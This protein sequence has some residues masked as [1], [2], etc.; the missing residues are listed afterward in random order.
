M[1]VL[2][3]PTSSLPARQTEHLQGL[4]QEERQ[5]TEDCLYLHIHR[6]KE[7]MFLADYIYIMRMGP[8]VSVP[9]GETDKT[10]LWSVWGMERLKAGYFWL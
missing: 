5:G 3:E 8:E 9:I 4:H 2:D 10:I 6:L 7:I 1:M